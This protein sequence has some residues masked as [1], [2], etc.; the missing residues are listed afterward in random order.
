M[1]TIK[2]KCSEQY[3]GT[4]C[5]YKVSLQST[6][7]TS[8]ATEVLVTSTSGTSVDNHQDDKFTI[9]H[10]S[11]NSSGVACSLNPNAR[12]GT[13]TI[14][15]L[16]TETAY[17]FCVLSGTTEWCSFVDINSTLPEN[18]VSVRT[19]DG[20]SDL[21]VPDHVLPIALCS[22]V[23]LVVIIIFILL[24][25]RKRAMC[26]SKIPVTKKYKNSKPQKY[27]LSIEEGYLST[28]KENS[29]DYL[30][31]TNP[32]AVGQ[33]T[34]EEPPSPVEQKQN[35]DTSTKNY[36]S[37]FFSK[38]DKTL[39]LATVLEYDDE[40]AHLNPED[41]T[42]GVTPLSDVVS[43]DFPPPPSPYDIRLLTI[44]EVDT[45]NYITESQPEENFTENKH[46]SSC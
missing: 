37:S 44:P 41:D 25:K 12:L 30:L 18:C 39:A 2:C 17:T 46:D 22:S 42:D 3:F 11:N 38:N 20:A 9:I 26:F 19:N 43:L 21:A 28:S 24:I 31:S 35:L 32:S 13:N 23:L 45:T 40:T 10:W 4:H 5:Q 15:N 6:K 27:G 8:H 7:S 16:Q 1:S 14:F 34:L 36:T 33:F 29:S